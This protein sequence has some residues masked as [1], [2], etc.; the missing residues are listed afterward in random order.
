MKR[1]L[2]AELAQVNAFLSHPFWLRFEAYLEEQYNM[3]V[4]KVMHQVLDTM[5]KVPEQEF[6]KGEGSGFYSA[7]KW[8]EL[9]QQELEILLAESQAENEDDDLEETTPAASDGRDPERG[10]PDAIDSDNYPF[11]S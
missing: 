6:V 5:H 4:T 7:W 1:D 8:P 11:G 9:L 2:Q 3:R 10:L